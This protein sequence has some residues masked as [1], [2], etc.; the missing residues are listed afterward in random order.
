MRERKTVKLSYRG[1]STH[2]FLK[3][4]TELVIVMETATVDRAQCI[5]PQSYI[6]GAVS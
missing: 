2:L 1:K 4:R 6:H 5:H 3:V